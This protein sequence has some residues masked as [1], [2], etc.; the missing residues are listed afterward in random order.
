MTKQVPN[1]SYPI[2]VL[3]LKK[4]YICFASENYYS[5]LFM[6]T[7]MRNCEIC[8]ATVCYV[9]YLKL[10]W[11]LLKFSYD[12][13]KCL[14]C[15]IPNRVYHF[16][17]ILL[18]NWWSSQLVIFYKGSQNSSPI[19]TFYSSQG[20]Y[21][22]CIHF[23]SISVGRRSLVSTIKTITSLIN[24]ILDNSLLYLTASPL[25]VSSADIISQQIYSTE[26]SKILI[27]DL[28]KFLTQGEKL[29]RFTSL[30]IWHNKAVT[31]LAECGNR[32]L[33]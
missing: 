26:V 27:N 6:L 1:S 14:W 17:I 29:S 18:Q 13:G 2:T 25:A 9:N 3:G 28:T 10:A 5:L 31:A 7:L 8:K 22:C 12:I 24:Y 32:R 15:K 33:Y 23:K 21:S 30:Y 4:Y 20:P 19:R 16:L 11:D